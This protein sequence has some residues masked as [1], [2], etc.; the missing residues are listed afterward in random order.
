MARSLLSDGTLKG[1]AAHLGPRSING[2]PCCVRVPAGVLRTIIH[3]VWSLRARYQGARGRR[4]PDVPFFR[5]NPSTASRTPIS[6][7]CMPCAHS[8]L[9]L[10]AAASIARP[11]SVSGAVN[12]AGC[13]IPRV[14][15]QPFFAQTYPPR[16]TPVKK[17]VLP[18][19]NS[20]RRTT[21]GKVCLLRLRSLGF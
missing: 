4:Q 11:C 8:S 15:R 16:S 12:C 21:C 13:Q 6:R 5:Q 7:S 20:A 14:G 9:A 17:R 2:S 19:A 3:P 18:N 10:R 1:D